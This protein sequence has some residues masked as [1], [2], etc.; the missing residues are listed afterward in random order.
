MTF[1]TEKN[2]IFKLWNE[3]ITNKN[4]ITIQKN[5]NSIIINNIDSLNRLNFSLPILQNLSS[6]W[7]MPDI[8]QDS[9]NNNINKN[10][11]EFIIILNNVHEQIIPYLHCEVVYRVGASGTIPFGPIQTNLPFDE[12]AGFD[13][14]RNDIVI[15][16]DDEIIT[17]ID[18]LVMVSMEQLS[19]SLPDVEYKFFCYFINPRYYVDE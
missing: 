8:L 2:K 1:N 5:N 13:L 10:V 18:Y 16:K 7:L 4:D 15:R 19:Q 11:Q 6:D 12:N 17:S 3:S 14:F 9:E